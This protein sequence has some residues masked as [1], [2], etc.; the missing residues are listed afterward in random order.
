[1]ALHPLAAKVATTLPE[2]TVTQP[3]GEGCDVFKVQDKV[4][5]LQ[6]H[7]HG[8]AAINLKVAPD[9]GAMLR[10]IYPYIRSGWHMNKQ[11]WISVYEDE[12]LDEALIEDLVLNSYALVV[13]KLKKLDRQRIALLKT[14]GS[15]V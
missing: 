7:L 12:E 13:S 2:V 11:H 10:D 3:F 5:M 14:V 4:F 6:F 15:R 1:M 9:H 8:Q